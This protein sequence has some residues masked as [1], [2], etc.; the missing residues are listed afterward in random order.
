MQKYG[1]K[2]NLSLSCS[3]ERGRNGAEV[4]KG[5]IRY[6]L[7]SASNVNGFEKDLEDFVNSLSSNPSPEGKG[8]SKRVVALSSGTAAGEQGDGYLFHANWS[9]Q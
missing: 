5:S 7:G 6:K 8:L 4:C 2:E 9:Q 3:H 1:K